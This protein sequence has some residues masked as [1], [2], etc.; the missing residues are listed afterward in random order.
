[1]QAKRNIAERAARWSAAHRK[2]AILGWIAFVVVSVVLGGAIGTKQLSGAEA[3]AGDS[4]RA[5]LALEKAELTPSDEMVMVQSAKLGAGDPAF[6]EA[7]G[8]ATR[9]L[10]A[11]PS[12]THLS[13]PAD[14]GG[15]VSADGHTALV[16]FQI[17]GT[18]D[19]AE[20]RVEASL[21]AT[22]AAQAA[23][24]D[25]RV[26]QFGGASANKAL[27]EV[28]SEDLKKAETTSLPITLVIL[29]LAFGA[30]VAALVPLLIGFSAVL[31]TVS[32]LA[33]PSQ[34]VPMDQNVA[35]VVVLVGLAVG[36]DYSLF[37]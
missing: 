24:P 35:S 5:A 27:E 9:K 10:A 25:V 23:H 34:L 20:E 36:V 19:Q 4:G 33:L 12:V 28:F 30:L 29:L 18:K 31:A 2:V 21:A 14:G 17:P 22:A 13:S 3:G 7:V 1:M 11:V 6:D 37:Y 32:L 15:Q 8:E 16:E 26:E